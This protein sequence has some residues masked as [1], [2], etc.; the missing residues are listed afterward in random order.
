MT[1]Y[2]PHEF[3]WWKDARAGKKVPMH[4]VPMQGF[5]AYRPSKNAAPLPVAIWYSK[6]GELLGTVGAENG[7]PRPFRN[8]AEIWVS[9]MRHHIDH[10]VFKDVVA[11]KPWPNEIIVRFDDGRS[12]SSMTGRN[13]A[14]DE[15]EMLGNIE[16][17]SRQAEKALKKGIPEN[18]EEAD[19]VS[20]IATKLI[21]YC[22]EA[23]A[24]RLALTKPFRDAEDQ[25]NAKWMPPIR[26]G[27]KLG[28]DLKTL[29]NLYMVAERKRRAEEAKK[30]AEQAGEGVAVVEAPVRV[31][32]RKTVSIVKETFV[33]IEDR[34]KVMGYLAG[35]ENM[36]QDVLDAIERATL[37]L[38]RAGISVPG[39]KLDTRE[40]A[41]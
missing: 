30:I 38:L 40:K 23:N 21:D 36:P 20:D 8:I 34:G 35:M 9:V 12:E 4:D 3:A 41:R 2:K 7:K 6:D 13:A 28:G 16:E 39:A 18:Q 14:S 15:T 37:R 5:Y 22:N 31:G 26:G 25:V 11:G 10:D 27:K 24:R 33:V 29:L 19:T 17:W 1:D 32:T